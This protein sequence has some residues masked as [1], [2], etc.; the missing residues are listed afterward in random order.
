MT[1][2][3]NKM[4]DSDSNS[5]PEDLT[6]STNAKFAKSYDRSR[7]KELLKKCKKSLGFPEG[8]TSDFILFCSENS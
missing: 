4:F 8:F 1:S 6:F 7:R 5:D 2:K 3:V